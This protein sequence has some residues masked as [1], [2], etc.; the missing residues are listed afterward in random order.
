MFK[1][2]ESE[3]WKGL[4]ERRGPYRGSKSFDYSCR[5]HGNCDY[6]TKKR[7]FFDRRNR[8]LADL[9]IEDFRDDPYF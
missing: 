3:N 1:N 4:K 9:Q 8:H 5:N 2:L 6:C 7:T